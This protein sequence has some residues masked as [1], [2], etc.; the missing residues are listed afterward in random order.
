MKKNK[1]LIIC[2]AD[3]TTTPR[4]KRL[5]LFLKHLGFSVSVIGFPPSQKIKAI[6]YHILYN[7]LE[8]K[9]ISRVINR[10]YSVFLMLF[11]KFFPSIKVVS[12]LL[13]KRYHLNNQKQIFQKNNFSIIFVE[14][15]EL[16]PF[17]LENKKQAKVIFDAREYYPEQFAA[18][19][20]FRI[21]YKPLAIFL[22]RSFFH[23]ADC[24]I[25][26]CDSLAEK[27]KKEFNL[28][29]RIIRSVPVYHDLQIKKTNPANIKIVHSGFATPDRKIEN[30]IYLMNLLDERF[31]LDFFLVGNENYIKKLKKIAAKNKKIH[32]C[33]P[34]KFDAII[35]TLNSY[36]IGIFLLEPTGFNKQ[37]ALPN[38]LFEFI[39]ARLAVAIG[40]SPEMAKVVN[41]YRCGIIS[42][43]FN[44]E[45]LAQLINRLTPVE[46]DLM[47]KNS[48]LAAKE[49]CFEKE[50]EKL[51]SI[52]FASKTNE[53][54]G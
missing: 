24:L 46:I 28:N 6:D 15:P 26:V 44:P 27:Y 41:Q 11:S 40:P 34:L 1:V 12:F 16:L 48:N 18:L 20:H 47:K 22:C 17:A 53:K 50:A 19:L 29:M 25:T 21:F 52:L 10:I 36:D 51:K 30:M 45:S 13:Q 42:P 8:S 54:S 35:P 9:K 39:Q 32:F 43:D 3:A 31:S 23:Q 33:P 38:K 7:P 2:L 5:S 37:F 49:L 14:N 4:P